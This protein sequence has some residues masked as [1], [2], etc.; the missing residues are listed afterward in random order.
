MW[1]VVVNLHSDI[2]GVYETLWH[3]VFVVGHYG[4]PRTCEFS[5]N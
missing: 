5:L 1:S 4:S 2:F 3:V